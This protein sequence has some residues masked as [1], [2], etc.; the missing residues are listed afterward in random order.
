MMKKFIIILSMIAITPAF[1]E[2]NR[3]SGLIDIPEARILPHL[4]YRIGVN[5]T[6]GLGSNNVI[7]GLETNF[8]SSLGLADKFEVY[9]DIYTIDNFTAAIGFCHN[10]LKND[11][12]ALSWGIHQISYALDVSEIGH[13]DS[14]GWHDDLT[15]YEGDYEK[16][17]EL[18]SAF[19]VSTYSLN[20]SVD[21]SLGLGRGRYV[22]YGTHSKYFNSNFYHDQGGD[23]AIGLIAG[24]NLKIAKGF[25]FM[26]DGDGRD[27]NLGFVYRYKPIELGL[28]ISKFEY[29]IWREQGESYQ[30]R[31]ALSV[32]YVKTEEKP[33]LGILAGTV[34]DQDGNSLIAKVGFVN[35][36]IPEIMTDPEFGD[37]KF[38]NIKPGVYDIYAQSA[39]Y[40]W[41]QKEIQIVPGK[42]VFCDFKLEKEKF[43][44]GDIV[45]KV[46]DLK[47]NK[48][49][50]VKLFVIKTD[51]K[52][53]SDTNGDFE[54][55][56]LIPNIYDIT[57]EALDY[58]T[59]Y[60]SVVVK[61]NEKAHVL[62]KMV[63]RGM[64]ITLKGIKFDLNKATI[65]PESYP[66]LDE[67][68]AILTNHPE[69]SVE[70]QGHTCSLGSSAYNLKL[71][72]MR[73]NSV[74]NYLIMKHMIEPYR[75]IARGCGET[76][77]IADNN[78]EE[79]RKKNR[80]VDFLILE[81]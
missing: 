45:G 62:I 79:G 74:R 9:L 63:K 56:G 8:H 47:T 80:R 70:I 39:G 38:A 35:K 46:V 66:I 40:E 28:A 29:F 1:A 18:G 23:W 61:E 22:G 26:I 43:E 50:V 53:E 12:I 13:G 48:P 69:I 71:S 81:E 77:P 76:Q 67:A 7:E 21:V 25:S 58:E 75:L 10:F 37:Y 65:K 19:F 34:F 15:Y 20:K 3:T 64:V 36:A 55:T 59:G 73:A 5:G 72:D 33:R 54:I 24:M 16:P 11:K 2:F 68:A 32:S 44:T 51:K 78:T 27:I 60:Y 6:F 52:A 57:A 14:T 31:L 4:G 49:L 42:V 30:P 17:F 41:S